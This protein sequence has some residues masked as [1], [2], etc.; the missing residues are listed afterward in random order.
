VQGSGT[1]KASALASAHQ[2]VTKADRDLSD[3]MKSSTPEVIR[4][5]NAM[6][7]VD[8]SN[9]KVAK[10]SKDAGNGLGLLSMAI[11]GLGPAIVLL[12]AGTA[13]LAVGFGAMGAAG[14]LA[15]VGI[16]RE[17]KAGT[18]LGGAYTSMLGTLSGD[19]T[20]L[21]HTAAAGVLA[22]FQQEVTN[23]QNQMPQLNSIIGEFSVITGKTAGNL[24]SGLVAAFIT[25]EPLARDVGVYVLDLSSKF[26]S[27]MSGGGVVSFGDYIRS[28]FPQVMATVES[29]VEAAVRLVAALAPLGMGTLGMLR[30]FSDLIGALPVD[31]LSNLATV[32]VPV[33]IGFKTFGLLSGGITAVST[34]L[35]AVG[36]SAETA[37]VGMRALNIAAGA[38]GAVI[39]IAMFAFT[40]HAASVQADQDAV[41][42]LTDALIA[43]HGAITADTVAEQANKLAKDG[44]LA[45][46]KML[47]YAVGDVTAAS[48]GN[49]DAMARVTAHTNDLV[50]AYGGV[51]PA[52]EKT[53]A[54]LDD[55]INAFNKV[56]DATKD[57][58][59]NLNLAK[60]AYDAVTTAQQQTSTSAGTLT[61]ATLLGMNAQQQSES[62]NKT[63]I[64]TIKTLNATMDEEISKELQLAGATSNVD[65][66]TLTMTTTLKANNLTMDEHTQKGIDDRRAIEGTVGALQSQ[67]DAQIKSGMSTAEATTKYE[68]ASVALLDQ[69][70]KMYGTTSQAYKYM[71]QLLAIPADVKTDLGVTGDVV[72]KAK[73][74]DLRNKVLSLPSHEDIQIEIQYTSKG[75]N[76][77]APSSVGRRAAGGPV[78]AGQP[79]IVGENRPELFVP[80]SNGTIIPR[81]PNAGPIIITMPPVSAVRAAFDTGAF[82]GATQFDVSSMFPASSGG[83]A[84]GGN[85]ANMAIGR[86]MLAMFGWGADQWPPLSALWNQESGWRTNALNASSGAYGIP[87]SLPASKMGTGFGGADYMTNPVTQERWG[88]GY[89]AGRYGNPA[90]AW[91]HEVAM[92]WYGNGTSNATPGWSVVGDKGP[93]LMKMRGGEMVIPNHALAGGSGGGIDYD[94]LADKLA[95][96]MSRVQLAVSAQFSNESVG[97]AV[98]TWSID[99]AQS[100]GMSGLRL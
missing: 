46:A 18:T 84:G 45:A 87:Q 77:T 39:A 42:S 67:R 31:V 10:S 8:D 56:N 5:A 3:M 50:T 34:A 15:I 61:T 89:I 65:Q 95:A 43:N 66:A 70:G 33:F 25:L 58:A 64:Q 29:V 91:A 94:K 83:G 28:V 44:T 49:A 93:E 4:A 51:A 23:L 63:Q 11:V 9:T 20:T 88:M 52:A 78:A 2:S 98:R 13:G 24:I 12:A 96:A 1:A 68:A 80:E 60:Q 72:A 16:M 40:S 74:N 99:E 82:N 7:Q 38:V 76:L 36:V 41:N 27:L 92:N 6:K 71:Q 79:Y 75:V 35:T 14:V 22:P 53:G 73:I 85:A 86:A 90:G 54:S 100:T 37:A 55:G 81:V 62:A 17:M 57:G 47:G 26:A 32:A 59:K 30:V 19:L 21:G 69:T 48:L 97:R